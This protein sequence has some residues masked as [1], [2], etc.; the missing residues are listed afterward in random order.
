MKKLILLTFALLCAASTF[1]Y[2]ERDLLQKQA[3]VNRLKD[4]L[5]MNQQ[6]VTYPDYSDRNGWDTF[7]G[8]FKD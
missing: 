2:T 6:W 4:I 1:A 3:D 5:V 7:L 8:T